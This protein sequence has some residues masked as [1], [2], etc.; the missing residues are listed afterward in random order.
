MSRRVS[1]LALVFTLHAVSVS[2]L[3]APVKRIDNTGNALAG[4]HVRA[5]SSQ[6]TF[7]AS[8]VLDVLIRSDANGD[9][10]LFFA[11]DDHD[12]RLAISGFKGPRP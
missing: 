5:S 12:Q 6:S 3:S 8:A 11:S 10:G 4:S 2:A 1:A 7:P 9:N